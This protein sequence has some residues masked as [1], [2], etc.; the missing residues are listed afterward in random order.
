MVRGFESF[1]SWF[2]GYEDQY[3]II[4]G[5][6]CDILMAEENIDFRATKDIDLV[7]ILEAMTP[8]FG[9]RFWNY[10]IEGQYQ[11]CSKSTGEPQFYRF[12]HPK[13][14]V[15]PAM[16][17]LFSRRS[18]AIQLPDDAVLTPLPIE[19][20]ISSLSAILLDDDYYT[21][22]RNGTVAKDV[23]EFIERMKEEPV[24]LK[25]LGIIGRQKEDI[26]D[27]LSRIYK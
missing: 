5:T 18:D 14:N 13:S 23:H 9:T 26:L 16:I 21:F 4:G 24:D 2:Q 1:Q 15:F 20:D 17:E 6:A 27:E 19:E 12:S 25:H 8:D 22:L 11:H 3:A 7:L 10:I